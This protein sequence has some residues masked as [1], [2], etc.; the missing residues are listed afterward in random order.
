[1]ISVGN[2]RH[3]VDQDWEDSGQNGHDNLRDR[4]ETEEHD[5]QR[6]QRDER[7]RIYSRQQR[8][9]G[10]TDTLVPP[11]RNTGDHA[12]DDRD[13]KTNRKI[14]ETEPHVFPDRAVGKKLYAFS[15]DFSERWKV[16]RVENFGAG[17]DFPGEKKDKDSN[18]TEPVGYKLANA[19]PPMVSG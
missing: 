18:E 16:E 3:G 10:S 17:G 1:M 12:K 5:D 13:Q 8:I 14:R 6:E 19:P 9:K 2:P 15:H 7:R 4:P 11:H